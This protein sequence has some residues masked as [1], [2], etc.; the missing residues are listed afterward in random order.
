MKQN[1]KRNQ[2]RNKRRNKKN[3]KNLWMGIMGASVTLVILGGFICGSL[4]NDRRRS[5]DLGKYGG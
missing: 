1:K 2:K 5:G 4:Q 3:T